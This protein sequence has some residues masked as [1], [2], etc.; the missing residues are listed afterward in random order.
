MTQSRRP[1]S[2]ESHPCIRCGACCSYFRVQFY[3]R[4]AEPDSEYRVP[5]DLTEN[6]DDFHRCIAEVTGLTMLWKVVDIS[7][8]QMDRCRLLA[9]PAPGAGHE[10]ID[11]H[12]AILDAL[13]SRDEQRSMEALRTHLQT[14]LRNTLS[15]LDAN[16]AASDTVSA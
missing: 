6:L 5:L 8:A 12:R 3:W 7:K 1:P 2:P 11:Q 15:Y 14:S 13:S 4:D 16:P 10:A 9:L